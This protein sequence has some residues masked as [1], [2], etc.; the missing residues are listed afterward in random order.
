MSL[1][2]GVP[3]DEVAVTSISL[4]DDEEEEILETET[5]R[6]IQTKPR[7]NV[8]STKSKTTNDSRKSV[9]D[10]F[11][12]RI[13]KKSL[14]W[15]YPDQQELSKDVE[16][17]QEKLRRLNVNPDETNDDQDRHSQSKKS[18]EGQT[19]KSCLTHLPQVQAFLSRQPLYSLEDS[20]EKITEE[21][22]QENN[23]ED[24]IP[25]LMPLTTEDSQKSL[26]KKIV[27][28]YVEKWYIYAN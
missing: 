23:T 16:S 17:I 14:H 10:V 3:G 25:I 15:L 26:R 24:M 13:T 8:Q 11:E 27:I 21:T 2:R 28:D 12:I 6:E 4:P 9:F 20:S 5:V 22:I 19:G 18:M 7:L 1:F